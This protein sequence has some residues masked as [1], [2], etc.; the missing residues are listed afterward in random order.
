MDPAVSPA[1]FIGNDDV[2]PGRKKPTQGREQVGNWVLNAAAVLAGPHGLESAA[3][4]EAR[5]RLKGQAL[6]VA[7]LVGVPRAALGSGWA[8]YE[9]ARV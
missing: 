7:E 1:G 6:G 2:G 5:A 3:T 8:C 4:G 9:L